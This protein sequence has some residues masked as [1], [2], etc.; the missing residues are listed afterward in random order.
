MFAAWRDFYATMRDQS[1]Y[2][3]QNPIES[4]L[5]K[6]L[7]RERHKHI[8]ASGAPDHAG[9]RSE[10][11]TATG[12]RPSA[13]F[14][15][16]HPSGWQLRPEFADSNM[17]CSLAQAFSAMLAAPR[18]SL[19]DRCVLLLLRHTGARVHEICALT[20]GGYRSHSATGIPGRALVINKGGRG[21]EDK[22]I[23]FEGRPDI[24][25]F[26]ERYVR[27]ERSRVDPQHRNT[28]AD[29]ADHEPIFL[30]RRATPLRYDTFHNTWRR[31][32][33][34]GRRLLPAGF[35]IHDLRHLL[36]TELLLKARQEYGATSQA[37]AEAKTS[38]SN[39]FGWRSLDTIAIY[40]HVLSTIDTMA[41]LT[42]LQR[43]ATA[44]TAADS[45]GVCQQATSGQARQTADTAQDPC[46]QLVIDQD[47]ADWIEQA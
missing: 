20:A 38:I 41:L 35:S 5:L 34:L 22:L 17:L 13:F 14:R 3:Y 43:D 12:R 47:L 37:Y 19:R 18:L 45:K 4:A 31:I 39:L 8:R 29:L 44:L 36:V 30:T 9:I 27:R 21:I 15:V 40:D 16:V 2:A 32:Y 6:R 42:A 10:T 33:P 46:H 28:V 24:P 11:H 7:N 23:T 26:I 25:L 1:L